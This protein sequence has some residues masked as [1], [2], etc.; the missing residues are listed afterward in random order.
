LRVK[1]LGILK[2]NSTA[3]MQLD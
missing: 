3:L 1:N 2:P